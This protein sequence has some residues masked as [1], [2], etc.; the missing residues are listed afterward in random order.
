MKFGADALLNVS[1][2]LAPSG[3]GDGARVFSV[4][5]GA[6]EKSA[7]PI[8]AGAATATSSGLSASFVAGA[9]LNEQGRMPCLRSQLGYRRVT[10][11]KADRK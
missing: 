1:T 6:A 5:N 4:S 9:A 2:T 7:Y 8:T 11:C 3:A 10:G